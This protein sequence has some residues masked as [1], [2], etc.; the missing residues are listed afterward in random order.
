MKK[1][2]YN[3]KPVLFVRRITNEILGVKGSVSTL[4]MFNG[5]IGWCYKLSFWPFYR[6]MS[7]LKSG[8][9]RYACVTFLKVTFSFVDPN[10]M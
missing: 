3:L 6:L 1:N 10:E 4:A 8:V 5:L 7:N 9:F 2:V